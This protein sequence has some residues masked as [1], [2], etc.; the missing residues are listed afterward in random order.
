M[1]IETY[2]KDKNILMTGITGF[3]GKV[4]LEKV[5]R[6]LPESGKLYLLVRG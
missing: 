5:L 2:F 4:L 1:N 3:V 6:S